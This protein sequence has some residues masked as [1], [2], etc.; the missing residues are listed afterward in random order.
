MMVITKA[1][2]G[3]TEID[4]ETC[5]GTTEATDLEANSEEIESELEQQEVHDE[6]AA[7]EMIRAQKDRSGDR[8]LAV[9]H[10]G[11]VT[12][13]AVPARRKAP[14]IVVPARR[15]VRCR[16]EPTVEEMRESP[17]MQ[18][19]H[20]KPKPEAATASRKREGIQ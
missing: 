11:L 6:E 12:D 10:R 8:H 4:M 17:G 20:K 16:K 15:K 5:L 3:E 19:R 2:L 7:V 9:R 1:S 13:R 14:R 18:Q